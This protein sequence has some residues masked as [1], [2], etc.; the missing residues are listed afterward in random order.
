MGNIDLSWD[1]FQAYI[2]L[3]VISLL[4][5]WGYKR[6]TRRR[7]FYQEECELLSGEVLFWGRHVEGAGRTARTFYDIDVLAENGK[8]YR[9]S[10][11]DMKA[12]KYRKRKKDIEILV[13]FGL[14]TREEL[15]AE[16]DSLGKDM[17]KAFG[18]R[19]Y[20]M[21]RNRGKIKTYSEGEYKNKDFKSLS[22]QSKA[23]IRITGWGAIPKE[24]M[25]SVARCAFFLASSIFFFLVSV[26]FMIFCLMK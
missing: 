24:C 7:K 10:V 1:A 18:S 2:A 21:Q 22:E 6:E 15:S 20:Y 11:A 23:Y 13:P 26:F 5:F 16:Y 4:L 3:L 19:E 9:C 8:M 14:E 25:P 12:R 17:Q